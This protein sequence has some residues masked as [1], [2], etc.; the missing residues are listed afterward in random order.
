MPLILFKINE[1]VDWLFLK[2]LNYMIIWFN[3]VALLPYKKII[4]K[5]ISKR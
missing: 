3:M 4:L 1:D 5:F 2:M